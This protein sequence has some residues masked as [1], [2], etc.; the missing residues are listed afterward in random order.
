MLDGLV[1]VP[2]ETQFVHGDLTGNV[3]V[4]DRQTPVILDVSPY[5][6]P[7]GW[8]AAIV[9]VDAVLW[10][11][12]DTSLLRTYASDA[13]TSDLVRRALVF[14]LVADQLS[15]HRRSE[16]LVDPYRIALAAISERA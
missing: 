10:Q 9:L 16:S 13:D 14:R 7:R 4:D 2:R 1:D 12:A 15:E 6:R 8:A 3:F 11:G 5:I